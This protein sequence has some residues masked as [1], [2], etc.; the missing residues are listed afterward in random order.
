MNDTPT[1]PLTAIEFEQRYPEVQARRALISQLRAKT[2]N[3]P[4]LG[5]TAALPNSGD[6]AIQMVAGSAVLVVRSGTIDYFF[7]SAGT[8]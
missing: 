4:T 5:T 1:K 7:S 6:I 8:L 3:L 2:F